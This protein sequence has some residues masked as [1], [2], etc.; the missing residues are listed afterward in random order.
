MTTMKSNFRS[1]SELSRFDTFEERF[2]YLNLTGKVGV[3]TFG[4]D[5]FLNQDFYRSTLWK[6]ARRDVIA[7]DLGCDLGIEG[8]EIYDKVYVHHMN[9]MS[10]QD[11]E[12]GD[13]SIIDPEYLISVTLKT[14]NAIHYGD[15]SQVQPALVER[16]P[17]D[18]TPWRQ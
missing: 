17:N 13:P 10:P 16:F 9:P 4:Y 5:R 15:I 14:H 2:E 12:S 3:E 1:Y 18:M 11:I 7:R 8:F 6:R